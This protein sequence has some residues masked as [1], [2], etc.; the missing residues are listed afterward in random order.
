M[1]IAT[2]SIACGH[3]SQKVGAEIV[4]IEGI[5]PQN[6]TNSAFTVP[7]EKTLYLRC[8]VCGQGSVRAPFD[9]IGRGG[10]VSPGGLP[11]SG[12]A[13]LPTDV[14]SAWAEARKSHS[15]GAF[16]AAEI[17]CRKILMHLAVDVAGSQPG[18]S[19][20]AYIND[21][22]AGNYI[23][24]G[25]KTVVDQVRNRGNKANHELPASTEQES[26]ATL[27]ITHHL[28]YGIYELPTLSAASPPAG[29]PSPSAGQPSPANP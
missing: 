29:A 2:W 20:V 28:L 13:N 22:E 25:L 23:M 6:L 5:S 18:K 4:F 24:A 19:F 10:Q 8:P 16:T 7:L 11:S 21:L 17:M 1:P 27:N 12:V 15:V 14:A 3:C 26:A 9:R